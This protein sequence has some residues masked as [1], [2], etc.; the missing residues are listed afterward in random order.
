MIK[1]PS[2]AGKPHASNTITMVTRPACGIPAA[3]ILANVAVILR[4]KNKIK[5]EQ[6]SFCLSFVLIILMR[7]PDGNDLSK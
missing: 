3:P 4:N 5:S 1:A 7:V 6:N 2:S